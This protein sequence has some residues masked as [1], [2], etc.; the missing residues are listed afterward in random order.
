MSVEEGLCWTRDGE[1]IFYRFRPGD[2]SEKLLVMIHGHG[3]HCGRYRKFFEN[4]G[5]FQGGIVSFDLRGCGRSSG[6]PVYVSSFEDYLSDIDDLLQ[7]LAQCRPFR[8][9]I[10]VFG[11]SL[12]GLIA[13]AWAQKNPGR[14]EKLILS[15]PLMGLFLGGFLRKLLGVLDRY[16]PALVISNPV[17]PAFLTHDPG[18]ISLYQQ[19]SLIRRRITIRLISEMLKY[20]SFL[21]DQEISFPF[22]VIIL[23]AGKDRI[24]NPLATKRFF[25]RLKSPGKALEVF[26]NF[27]H[28]IF[29]ETDQ[30]EVFSRLKHHLHSTGRPP[31]GDCSVE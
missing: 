16:C 2:S 30:Q 23:M 28:E 4:L 8:G 7:F 29:N 12:G 20:S 9:K 11:H 27:Y 14:V 13:L 21:A 6:I 18:E 3:E 26:D 1:R 5:D 15:S 10:I 22:P 17:K 31:G 25:E 19:D 24:V